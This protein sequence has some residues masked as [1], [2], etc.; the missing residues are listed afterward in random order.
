MTHD[1][2]SPVERLMVPMPPPAGGADWNWAAVATSTWTMTARRVGLDPVLVSTQVPY[3]GTQTAVV[4]V[5][6]HPYVLE[7][8]RY[9][10]GYAVRALPGSP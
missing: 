6:G 10:D 5:D 8:G 1:I 4:A 7:V 2:V 3:P 9:L